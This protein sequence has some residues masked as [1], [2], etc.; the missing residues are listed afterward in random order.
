MFENNI[1]KFSYLQHEIP[2]NI[3]IMNLATFFLSFEFSLK[4]LCL[5]KCIPRQLL[6]YIFRKYSKHSIRRNRRI[7]ILQLKLFFR[8]S[9]SMRNTRRKDIKI[10]GQS[11]FPFSGI[12]INIYVQPM[13]R[14]ILKLACYYLV[15]KLYLLTL[16]T[17]VF[18]LSQCD[19]ECFIYIT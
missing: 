7:A 4:Y 14:V 15:N 10:F 13:R 6:P 18:F 1:S 8:V 19:S 12:F 5:I 2:C 3:P 17:L 16:M 11:L 9:S